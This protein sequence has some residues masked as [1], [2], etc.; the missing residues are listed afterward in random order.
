MAGEAVSR[1][2]LLGW[3]IIQMMYTI[4]DIKYSSSISDLEWAFQRCC[5]ISKYLLLY[6]KTKRSLLANPN[7]DEQSINLGTG[8]S[9]CPCQTKIILFILMKHLPPLRWKVGKQLLQ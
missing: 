2:Y 3:T 1:F 8:S 4:G 5:E 9:E 7:I 6:S